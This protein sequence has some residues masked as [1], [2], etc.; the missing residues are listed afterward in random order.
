MIMAAGLKLKAIDQKI[1][2]TI[3]FARLKLRTID[4]KYSS[5]NNQPGKDDSCKRRC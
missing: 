5:Y 4:Q 1:L 3:M 2:L